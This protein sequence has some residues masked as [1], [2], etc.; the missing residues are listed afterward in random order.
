MF[1]VPY[2]ITSTVTAL[3]PDSV[4]E[5]RHPLGHHWRW[6]FEQ[7]DPQRTRVT[8]TFDYRN[9]GTLKDTLKYYDRMGFVKANAKGIEATLVKLRNRYPVE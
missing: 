3:T 6:E 5:W 7:V 8:E 1:G 2:R 9:T 4:I